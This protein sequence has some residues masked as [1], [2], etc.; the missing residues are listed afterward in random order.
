MQ[1]PVNPNTFANNPLD[2]AS[3]LRADETWLEEKK[4]DSSSVFV[5]LWRLNPMLIPGRE[6]TDPIDVAWLTKPAIDSL[7][8]DS[9]T[10]VFLGMR[11][12]IAH[13]AVDISQAR[14]PE[15]S[16][17][18]AGL[19]IFGDLRQTVANIDHQEA[20]ILA[21]AKSMVDWH[22]RHRFCANCGMQTKIMEAGYKRLCKGCKSEHFPRTDPV[23]IMIATH[24]DRCLLGRQKSW[25]DKMYSALAGFVEPGESIEEAAARDCTR[26]LASAYQASPTIRPSRGLTHRH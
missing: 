20:A 18:L 3:Y 7:N 22:T 24:N 2:R 25:P 26:K 15:N 21:Q 1:L 17:P 16:G 10:T 11:D 8:L 13:F 12:G 6:K 14:D 5:P 19:G 4:K 23:V 9:P